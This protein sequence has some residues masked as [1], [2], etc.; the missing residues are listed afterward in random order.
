MPEAAL[1]A[2]DCKQRGGVVARVDLPVCAFRLKD[3]DPC[4]GRA[5]DLAYFSWCVEM[6]ASRLGYG[7]AGDLAWLH[8]YAE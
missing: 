3:A 6:E 2:F 1:V 8:F 4:K 5:L 7:N